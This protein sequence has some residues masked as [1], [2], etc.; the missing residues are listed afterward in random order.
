LTYNF[1]TEEM[2]QYR[3]DPDDSGL[4]FNLKKFS[5]KVL[6]TKFS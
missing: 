4:V 1:L 3:P 5:G 2:A 6:Q